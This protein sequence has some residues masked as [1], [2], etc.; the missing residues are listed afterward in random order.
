MTVTPQAEA[1]IDAS[2]TI[3]EHESD[4]PEKRTCQ[5]LESAPFP[6]LDNVATG[7]ENDKDK[8]EQAQITVTIESVDSTLSQLTDPKEARNDTSGSESPF[9]TSSEPEWRPF[10]LARA[11]LTALLVFFVL[12]I[13]GL[14]ALYGYSSQHGGLVPV[15]AKYHQLWKYGPNTVLALGIALWVQVEN[16]VKQLIAWQIL[17]SES[18]PTRADAALKLDYFSQINVIALFSSAKA[19]HWSVALT[20]A[21]TLLLQAA[22]IFSTGLLE[23]EARPLA[24]SV[25]GLGTVMSFSREAIMLDFLNETDEMNTLDVG[26]Y[27]TKSLLQN[28][29]FLAYPDGT[30][31]SMAFEA[32]K[33]PIPIYGPAEYEAAGSQSYVTADVDYLSPA[34][35]CSPVFDQFSFQIPLNIGVKTWLFRDGDRSV[36]LAA[37]VSNLPGADLGQPSSV[38]GEPEVLPRLIS[39]NMT[40]DGQRWNGSIP[41]KMDWGT[42]IAANL[43][44][45][46]TVFCSTRFQPFQTGC[47]TGRNETGLMLADEG[48]CD[49]DRILLVSS[50]EC[51][52]RDGSWANVTFSI[53]ECSPRD[54]YGKATIRFEN[55][56]NSPSE[57]MEVIQ[58]KENDG[59]GLG[60][61][62][63]PYGTGLLG[64]TFL[65][66]SNNFGANELVNMTAAAGGDATAPLV[67]KQAFE[68][69]YPSFAVQVFRVASFVAGNDS[70]LEGVV[71]TV[72]S[73]LTVHVFAL[74]IVATLVGLVCVICAILVCWAWGNRLYPKPW[75]P[76]DPAT[77]AGSIVI[78]ETHPKI[79]AYSHRHREA[80]QQEQWWQPWGTTHTSKWV[81]MGALAVTIA[82]LQITLSLS[83]HNNGLALVG[84]NSWVHYSWLLLPALAIAALGLMVE[85]LKSNL[86]RTQPFAT[87]KRGGPRAVGAFFDDFIFGLL[88]R[89][90]WMLLRAR[91]LVLALVALAAGISMP[92]SII[93]VGDL[94]AL[95]DDASLQHG[96]HL[97]QVDSF[98]ESTAHNWTV[99]YAQ[100]FLGLAAWS[101]SPPGETRT[102]NLLPRESFTADT[103]ATPRFQLSPGPS[104]G[105]QTLSASLAAVNTLTARGRL[106]CTFLE[107][108]QC[109][110]ITIPSFFDNSSSIP[111]NRRTLTVPPA[112]FQREGCPQI[113]PP[114]TLSRLDGGY[115]VC[116]DPRAAILTGMSA[117]NRTALFSG[118]AFTNYSH[119]L[120][121]TTADSALVGYFWLPVTGDYEAR[122][123]EVN[124]ASDC[125]AILSYGQD[126]PG[127]CAA[128]GM[129]FA[130]CS[131]Y[132]EI[133][134]AEV[135]FTL[136]DLSVHN[137]TIL[138]D[139]PKRSVHPYGISQYLESWQTSLF[140]ANKPALPPDITKDDLTMLSDVFKEVVTTT[141][142]SGSSSSV[143]TIDDLRNK[144][145]AS[146]NRVTNALETL[147]G[148]TMARVARDNLTTARGY[149][150][151]QPVNVTFLDYTRRRVVQNEA[152]TRIL[153]GLLGAMLAALVVGF[154]FG[155]RELDCVLPGAPTRLT[156][157][158]FIT[159]DGRPPQHQIHGKSTREIGNQQ[160]TET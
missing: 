54:R 66:I 47:G 125:P 18:E 67:A 52:P 96:I 1:A 86:C 43:P 51:R 110:A 7:T 55:V 133:S 8:D 102:Y 94:F 118:D 88:P 87:L 155:Q 29:P 40:I 41:V 3:S 123:A 42:T 15:A 95:S 154:V 19:R 81:S 25:D 122:K 145:T 152:T 44:L 24:Y 109:S 11:T 46:V 124:W 151:P 6:E 119:N 48:P 148:Q 63:R 112:L 61:T 115:D 62:R 53:L 114:A 120:M 80:N 113:P 97:W 36:T 26:V 107:S 106:N 9:A 22:S 99:A 140:S 85:D 84:V 13:A 5:T 28:Q 70:T 82:L 146:R 69:F 105:N 71:D 111:C 147:W 144:T 38:T 139:R 116:R 100:T 16:R 39:S 49:V 37:N 60:E 10:F 23:R 160:Q 20:I 132:L 130:A 143:L 129:N 17:L 103:F 104:D 77:L 134:E 90:L 64:A 34:V 91:H 108:S 121:L 83:T 4:I 73:R 72:I 2:T 12:L 150:P 158:R 142:T 157:G 92:L 149:D 159:A 79:Q 101:P 136:P 131:P 58:L 137:I 59:S 75:L 89:R 128:G 74:A 57:K 65:S 76:R 30:T 78:L 93:V 127:D 45:N 27:V 50:R 21:S 141:G 156:G 56:D 98:N 68:A 153:Q 126:V 32:L 14:G 35:D 135:I 138:P 33:L 117:D 31:K